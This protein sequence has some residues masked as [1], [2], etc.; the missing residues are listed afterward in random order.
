MKKERNFLET[1]IMKKYLSQPEQCTCG[2]KKITLNKF[3]N[4]KSTGFCLLMQQKKL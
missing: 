4:N 3:T 1:A 2:N